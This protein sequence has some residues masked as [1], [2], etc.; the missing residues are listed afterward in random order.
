MLQVLGY[1]MSPPAVERTEFTLAITAT[2][3]AFALVVTIVFGA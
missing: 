2:V 3:L 1:F